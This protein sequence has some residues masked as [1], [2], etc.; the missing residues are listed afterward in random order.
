MVSFRQQSFITTGDTVGT[1]YPDDRRHSGRNNIRNLN[2]RRAIGIAT[3]A[4]SAGNVQL[5]QLLLDNFA[6]IDAESPNG[7]T[8]L[9][10]AARYG[11]ADAVKVLLDAGADPTLKNAQGLS[12]VDF[13]QKAQRNDSANLITAAIRARKSNGAW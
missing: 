9:M 3:L 10:M 2:F 7:S 5:V 13:A 1:E 12:A 4:A 11:S 8:P 6:Y